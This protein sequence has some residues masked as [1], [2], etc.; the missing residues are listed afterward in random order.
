[1]TK[2]KDCNTYFKECYGHKVYKVGLSL[3]VTCPNRD[4]KVGI[5]GCHFCSEGGSG[6]FSESNSLNVSEQLELGIS[7]LS[8]KCSENTTYIAYFQS[9][10]NTYCE[11]VLLRNAIFDAM[12]HPKVEAVS[13]ATRPDCIPE[14]ILEVFK[15]F[16]NE[17]GDD[18]PRLYV[19]LGLQTSN[20]LTAKSFNRCYLTSVYD[21]AVT[22]LKQ[23]G[24][25]VITHVIFG[26]PGETE[27]MMMDTIRH[28]KALRTDGVKFTC[29]Y[30]LKNS[31]YEALWERGEINVL[32]MEEYFDLVDKAI[33]ILGEDII[34]HRFTG[35]GPKKILLA[36][37]WTSNKRAVVNYINRRFK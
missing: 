29:L 18:K 12:K 26:L 37:L 25:N 34:I 3:N 31:F 13:V 24:V 8:N 23:I 22:K 9:F 28:I 21:E 36:P 19:E 4:G 1:M 16:I 35:D 17:F 6:E 10:T 20:D 7:K 27:E 11:P 30:I 32:D 2:C 33:N 15:D 14:E 5:G